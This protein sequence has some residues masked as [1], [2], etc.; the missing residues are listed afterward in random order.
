LPSSSSTTK[1]TTSSSLPLS[2]PPLPSTPYKSPPGTDRSDDQ[3]ETLQEGGSESSTSI[4]FE[5]DKARAVGIAMSG[6]G[7]GGGGGEE[8]GEAVEMEEMTPSSP[9]SA[10]PMRSHSLNASS[11][12]TPNDTTSTVAGSSGEEGTE[13]QRSK[14]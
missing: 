11:S 14:E 9:S 2:L 4:H 13:S 10:Y 12:M 3:E 8:R 1:T 7:G 6:V 5:R